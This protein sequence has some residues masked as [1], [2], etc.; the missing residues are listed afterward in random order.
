LEFDA[1]L[2]EARLQA[3]CGTHEGIEGICAWK[4]EW[5]EQDPK[6]DETAFREAHPE[7]YADYL[8][9]RAPTVRVSVLKYR[10]YPVG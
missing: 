3:A 8:V 6:F 1:D 7:L 4:R 10:A 2:L 9:D 5:Q